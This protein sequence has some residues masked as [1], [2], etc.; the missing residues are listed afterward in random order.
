MTIHFTTAKSVYADN[1]YAVF[2]ATWTVPTE[3]AA[4]PDTGNVGTA[5]TDGSYSLTI[6]VKAGNKQVYISIIGTYSYYLDHIDVA[7]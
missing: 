6:P 5:V 4:Y 7:F 3:D 1:T 2:P